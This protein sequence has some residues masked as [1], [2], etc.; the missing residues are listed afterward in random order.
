MATGSWL[1]SSSPSAMPKKQPPIPTTCA[2]C[3]S[4]SPEDRRILLGINSNHQ[5]IYGRRC[6]W[7]G[8][9]PNSM[10]AA[11]ALQTSKTSDGSCMLPLST[12]N[13]RFVC[14]WR[15]R[16]LDVALYSSMMESS[17]CSVITCH[18]AGIRMNVLRSRIEVT[19]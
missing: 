10:N 16:G 6:C 19:Q 11:C 4:V 18:F 15:Y 13:T 7:I 1:H 12:S 5:K 9:V 17:E 8:S 2:V 14:V 3:R